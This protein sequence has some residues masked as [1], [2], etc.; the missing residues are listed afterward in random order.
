MSGDP[1]PALP[2]DLEHADKLLEKAE[3]LMRRHKG[4]ADADAFDDLPVLTDIVEVEDPAGDEGDDK[5]VDEMQM[6]ERL[7]A[8]DA[9][10]ARAIEGWM[11]T[12]L[13]QIVAREFATMGERIHEQ[14][15]AHLRATLLPRLSQDISALLDPESPDAADAD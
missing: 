5:P 14:A 3:A 1:E 9:R 12:E 11:E 6:V 15:L 7:I 2:G 8:L 13:P 4:S 10:L